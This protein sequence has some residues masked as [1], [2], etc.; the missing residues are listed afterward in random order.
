MSFMKHN[1]N[2]LNQEDLLEYYY[3]ESPKSGEIE[4]H[5]RICPGC[6]KR[7]L[8]LKSDLESVSNNFKHDF[9]REQRKKIMSQASKVR[10]AKDTSRV[11]WLRPAFVTIIIIVLFIGIYSRLNHSP[12]R[13]TEKDMSD[14]IILEYVTELAQQP[15]T[16]SLDYLSF[17][18]EEED[19]EESDTYSF[20]KL[21]IFGYWP[22]LGA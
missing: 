12:I 21:E 15:L 22:E 13:Y 19:Q 17:Q 11:K 1:K 3:K 7:Y 20:E 9:W 16:S 4:E 14:E 10:E 6:H 8:E 2:H 18:E 5:I